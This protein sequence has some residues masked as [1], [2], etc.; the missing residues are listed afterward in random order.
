ME[1]LNRNK[2]NQL[3]EMSGQALISLYMPTHRVG[4][5]MQ[6][7]P[8]RFKNLLSEAEDRLSER[9]FRRPE[10]EAMLQPAHRLQT[11]I[12]FWQ[13]LSDGLA[14]FIG[15][16]FMKYFRLPINFEQLLII[17]ERFHLKPL[18]PLLSKNG[19][20]FVLVLSQKQIRL[21]EG[22]LFSIDEIDLE[23]V[24]TSLREA[25]RYDHPE[26][27]LQFHTGATTPSGV[28]AH[29]VSFHGQG[30]S[31]A[32][33]KTDLLRYFQKVDHG[34]M[35][36]LADEQAPLVL[37]G[38]DYLLPI[39]QRANN[40]P[41][42]TTE[43]IEG[44]YDQVEVGE[45][46]RGAWKIVEPIF[47]AGQQEA[48]ARFQELSGSGSKLASAKVDPV[49]QAAHFGRVETLFVALGAQ[50]WGTYDKENNILKQHTEFRPG[51]LDLLDLAASQTLLNGGVVYALEPENL[52]DSDALAAIFRYTLK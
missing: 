49:L 41:H 35:E 10:I 36:M 24:P 21:F 27:Q 4:R 19:H 3:L 48:L 46:H 11:D 37:A 5:E 30:V 28:G 23:D 34:L 43:F 51:D 25:L 26:K 20:F 18:L 29:A 22:S 38:V 33:A 2:L 16:K 8:I 13:H 40:Y 7:D 45:L 15:A 50:L 12:E 9:G 47:E 42:L 32:D 31:E 6:Q 17:A 14:L 52:P 1:N 44:N 39:Y